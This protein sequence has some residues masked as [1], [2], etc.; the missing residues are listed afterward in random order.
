MWRVSNAISGSTLALLALAQCIHTTD[1]VNADDDAAVLAAKADPAFDVDYEASIR[2]YGGGYEARVKLEELPAG[3]SG[4]IRLK[5]YNPTEETFEVQRIQKSC[6]C[7]SVEPAE[8]VLL[9]K[10]ELT[11]KFDMRVPKWPKEKSTFIIVSL[12]FSADHAISIYVEMP[13]AEVVSFADPNFITSATRSKLD[14][15]F[16]IPALVTAPV[17]PENLEFSV[18]DSLGDVECK[19]LEL[20]DKSQFVECRAAVPKNA[21]V[22]RSGLIE[23]RDAVSGNHGEIHCTIE[24]ARPL[25]V[26]PSFIKFAPNE[27]GEFSARLIARLSDDVLV[28]PRDQLR[29]KANGDQFA[30]KE[31]EPE[32]KFAC[33]SG[34]ITGK[35]KRLTKGVYRL[36]LSWQAPV[37]APGKTADASLATTVVSQVTISANTGL[38]SLSQEVRAVF[39]AR[40]DSN[41]KPDEKK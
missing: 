37:N 1:V 40:T 38:E 3:K 10:G 33:K 7:M 36:N 34:E 4:I 18:A 5:L 24:P 32:F 21:N 2:P 39:S 41:R 28:I 27:E 30:L 29:R 23:M 25:V 35:V 22:S 26:V 15:I 6:N 8:K 14:H 9:P 17:I 20:S 16:R 31:I 13:V 12:F 11:V 19:F